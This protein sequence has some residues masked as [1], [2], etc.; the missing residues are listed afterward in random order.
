MSRKRDK[1]INQT[2]YTK[3]FLAGK[4]DSV[5]RI[6][7][8]E[9]GHAA[10]Y[11]FA[12]ETVRKLEAQI[13]AAKDCQRY[14]VKLDDCLIGWFKAEDVLAALNKAKEKAPKKEASQ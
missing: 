10:Y 14:M 13:Q 5:D 8:L 9:T 11:K 12:E 4:R 7:L 2:A 3:G 6:N 1:Q